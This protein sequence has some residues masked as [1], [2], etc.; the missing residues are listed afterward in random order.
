M[1]V[2]HHEG[3]TF[4]YRPRHDPRS[5]NYRLTAADPALLARSRFWVP[6]R[7]VLDQGREGACFPQGTFV[8]MADGSQKTI[9]D[10]RTLDEV[11][12]AE[13]RTGTVL[14]TMA[15][16][17]SEL[18]V[19]K[20]SGH[21]AIRCTPEHPFLTDRGY[22][23]AAELTPVDL[24]AVTKHH[25]VADQ[26]IDTASLIDMHGFR[27]VASGVVNRGGVDTETTPPPPL[28]PKTPELGRLIGLYAAEGAVTPNKVTWSLAGHE[29]NTLAVEI[30][31]LVKSTL[32]AVAR[33]QIRPNGSVNV[34]LYG[35]HWRLLFG[36]L[37]PG[38]T[39]HGD[40]HLSPYVT[41]GPTPYLRGVLDGWLAGDGHYRRSSWQGVSVSR[42]LI[43]DM[44][45][46]ATS[47]G[48]R[49]SVA[50]SKPSMNRHAATRQTR[51]DL[52]IG[53]GGNRSAPQDDATVWRR[54][55]SSEPESYDGWVHNIHVEGDESY[56]AEGVGVHNCIG[57]G[58]AH[59]AAASP[60]RVR[61]IDETVAHAV[62][63]RAQQLDPWPG[64]AYEGTS[65]LAGMKVGQER[66]WWSGYRWAMSMAELRAALE[67]GPVVIGVEW[68]DGMYKAP[69]GVVTATGRVVG[70]HALL[71]TGYTPRHRTLKAPAYRWR[72]S[73][74]E[75]Y[76]VR[77]NAYIS[78]DDLYEILFAAGGEA[79]V[80]VGRATR[81]PL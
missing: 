27:G 69:G 14:Q 47:L 50:Q 57:H 10:I 21:L 26:P 35:K 11:V 28:L 16:R 7:F 73:W 6:S 39:K 80:P 53:G 30:V 13:G 61:G 42:R 49:P 12:T 74:S 24:V 33:T 70:G 41:S 23:A 81:R 8:R 1:T 58:V 54:V 36:T 62:Y 55:V 78:A 20:L 25:A 40:K 9:E 76:G 60:V 56:V 2:T 63:K 45:A 67:E 17:A 66:G 19:V 75:S 77:G 59:E 48:L 31:D 3:R 79:A 71:V 4:D 46:I 37:V 68:R 44:H 65:V 18:V 72:N 5:L 34:I 29:L 51:Y 32:G 52:M 64:E 38:T 15:R 22:V 43:L